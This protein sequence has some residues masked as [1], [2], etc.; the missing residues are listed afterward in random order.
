MLCQFLL[1]SKVTKSYSGILTQ[2]LYSHSQPCSRGLGTSTRQCSLHGSLTW[3]VADTLV[4][5]CTCSFKCTPEAEI[6]NSSHSRVPKAQAGYASYPLL[7]TPRSMMWNSPYCLKFTPLSIPLISLLTTSREADP[8]SP[9]TEPLFLSPV[10]C[11]SG[12]DM[13]WKSPAIPRGPGVQ[14][15]PLTC[16]EDP[17]PWFNARL[18]VS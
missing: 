10:R 9:P 16:L 7:L 3:S 14:P 5:P 1:Y 12:I 13:H 8:P 15:P 4:T 6:F 18:S 11:R 17:R 2:G